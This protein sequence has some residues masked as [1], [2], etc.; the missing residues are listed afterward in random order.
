M[1]LIKK[2]DVAKHFADRRSMSLVA[3]RPASQPDA[4]VHSGSSP[5]VAVAHAR[6]FTKDF[7]E[8]HSSIAAAALSAVRTVDSGTERG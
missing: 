7:S 1:T 6:D 5:G 3:A 4:P 2:A 8:E